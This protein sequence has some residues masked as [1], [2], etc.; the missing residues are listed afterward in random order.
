M[1]KSPTKNNIFLKKCLIWISAFLIAVL[2][3]KIVSKGIIKYD[4]LLAFLFFLLFILIKPLIG[5]VFSIPLILYFSYVDLGPF[6][7]WNYIISF[8]IFI[9]LLIL[10]Q[11]NK[12]ILNPLSRKILLIFILYIFLSTCINWIQGIP[13]KTLFYNDATLFSTLLLGFCVMFFLKNK[14]EL[15]IF[16]YCLI[17]FMSFSAFVGIMQFLGFDF[18]WKLREFWGVSPDIASDII[19]R[20]RIPGLAFYSIPLGYELASIVPLIYGLLISKNIGLKKPFLFIT[21]AICFLALL[22]TKGR[23]AI[24]GSLIG[25]AVITFWGFKLKKRKLNSLIIISL[26]VILIFAAAPSQFSIQR[27]AFKDTSAIIRLP[28]LIISGKT[29]LEHPLGMGRDLKNYLQHSSEFEELTYKYVRKYNPSRLSE[30][31][32]LLREKPIIAPHNQ[33]INILLYYGIFG[34]LLL[35]FFYYFIFK[36]LYCTIQNNKNKPLIESIGLGLMGSFIA[37]VINS[38]FHNLG[39]FLVDPFNWYFIGLTLFLLNYYGRPSSFSPKYKIAE[40]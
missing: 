8:L 17:G 25:I 13:P 37:Y 4:I 19:L 35:I 36:G 14:K 5:L 10:L 3:G 12:L 18:F 21:F 38:L 6:S 24:I 9:A 15:K 20:T 32:Y 40:D 22:A 1:E 27:F 2:I 39:P 16:I 30:I 11:K 7:P 29:F 23:S 33:F 28:A 31:P 26:L 34:F